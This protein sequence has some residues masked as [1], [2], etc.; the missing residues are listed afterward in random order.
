MFLLSTGSIKTSSVTSLLVDILCVDVCMHA[1]EAVIHGQ[2]T[3]KFC[4]QIL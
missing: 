1:K 2:C 3:E 4:I